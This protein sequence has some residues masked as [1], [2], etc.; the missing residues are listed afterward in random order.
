MKRN[1]TRPRTFSSR[2]KQCFGFTL[3]ELLVVI[4]IIAI[5]AAMLLPALARAKC[6]ANQIYCL[7]NLKQLTTGWVMYAHDNSDLCASNAASAPFDPNYGN[8]VTGWLDWGLGTPGNANT[9]TTFLTDAALG[10]YMSKALGS[11]KCPAD[12]YAGYTPG[13]GPRIRTVS[14]NCLIGDYLDLNKSKYGNS[15]Y[16][17]FNKLTDFTKPG[18]ADTFVL[19]DECPDSINDGLFEVHLASAIWGDVVGSLHCGGCGFS[20]ADGHAEIHKWLDTN[21]KFGV[22]RGTCP[23]SSKSS[24]R[25]YLWLQQHA[26]ALK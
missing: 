5:L 20:F 25:D 22:V 21:T 14:M 17:V 16:R 18:A 4:A 26:S 19:L 13:V 24:P 8:W 12:N 3:I 10:P 9:N 6:R 7:N 23:G 1:S 15:S 2:N 11:Y